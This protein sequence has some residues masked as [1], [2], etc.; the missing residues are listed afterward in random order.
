MRFQAIPPMRVAIIKVAETWRV[1]RSKVKGSM[2]FLPII[3]ATAEPIKKGAINSQAAAIRRALRGEMALVIIMVATTFAASCMPFV[4][5]KKSTSAT[6]IRVSNKMGGL[7]V[8]SFS[9]PSMTVP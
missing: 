1:F 4:K 9:S 7:M 8:I 6:T 2:I 3:T 5:A